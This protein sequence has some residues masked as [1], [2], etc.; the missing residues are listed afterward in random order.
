[1]GETPVWDI[2]AGDAARAAARGDW[3][4]AAELGEAARKA[5]LNHCE[6]VYEQEQAR[7]NG[8]GWERD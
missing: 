7:K 3:R 2:L 4:R 5:W 1:M 6:A 8:G